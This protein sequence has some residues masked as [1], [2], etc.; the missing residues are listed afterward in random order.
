[1]INYSENE[2][3]FFRTILLDYNIRIDGR[4]K[5]SIRNH[6]IIDNIIPSCL[7]SLKLIYNDNQK[8]MIFAIK[9]EII[10]LGE[11]IASMDRLLNVSIDSMY[12]MEDMKLKKQIENYIETLIFSKVP[13]ENLKIDKNNTGDYYWKIYLDIY[14]FD[15]L[16]MSLLQMLSIGTKA[17]I[18]KIKLPN[19]VLFTNEIT[20]NKEFDLVENYEDVSDKEKEISVMANIDLPDIYVLAVLNNEVYFDPTEEE[21]SV[22]TSIVIISSYRGKIVNIQSIGSSV[23]IHKLVDLNTLLKSF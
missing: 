20:G 3:E 4:G 10:Q 15:Y 17:V 5:S 8:E 16:K 9:G 6:E 13:M 11:H 22:A 2:R 18:Q 19:L 12:K 21:T 7:S 14:V 23:E 1:M